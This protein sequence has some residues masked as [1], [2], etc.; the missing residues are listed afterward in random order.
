MIRL[1][2]TVAGRDVVA[3]VADDHVA[4]CEIVD[5]VRNTAATERSASAE[6]VAFTDAR[7]R[8]GDTIDE[9]GRVGHELPSLPAL[10]LAVHVIAGVDAGRVVMLRPQGDGSMCATIGRGDG[11]DVRLASNAVSKRHCTITVNDATLRV[12]DHGSRNGTVVRGH[13][14][15]DG[16]ADVDFGEPIGC[17]PAVVVVRAIPSPD[18]PA[19]VRAL[20]ADAPTGPVPY[21]RSP[22]DLPMAPASDIELPAPPRK[23]RTG[24]P[25]LIGLLLPMAMAAGLVWFTGQLL[26]ALFALMGPVMMMVTTA[27]RAGQNR[28]VRKKSRRRY[29]QELADFAEEL[30]DACNHEV[31]RRRE[32]CPDLA[33]LV[34]RGQCASAALWSRRRN[35]PNFMTLSVGLAE[36][37]WEPPIA[38]PPDDLGDLTDIVEAGR[39]LHAA[40]VLVEASAGTTIGLAGERE[41]A[42]ASARG[43]L[44]QIAILHGPAEVRALIVTSRR[45]ADDWDWAKWLP[46]VRPS[47][48]GGRLLVVVADDH[49]LVDSASIDDVLADTGAGSDIVAVIDTEGLADS[50]DVAIRRLLRTP[51][52]PVTGIV[53]APTADGLP[54]VCEL[55]IAH[56]DADGEATC[57]WPREAGRTLDVVIGGLS[58]PTA[59][60]VAR[61]LARLVDPDAG[62]GSATLPTRVGQAELLGLDAAAAATVT[63]RWMA[64]TR[65]ELVVGLGETGPVSIDL[66]VHGPHVLVVG[67]RGTGKT[68]QLAA[69]VLALAG[70]HPP[71]H[72]HLV[73]WG[74]SF[75]HLHRLPHVASAVSRIDETTLFQFTDGLDRE[76][77][78]RERLRSQRGDAHSVTDSGGDSGGNTA[79][80][81]PSDATA[82]SS[83]P[84]LVVVIDDIDTITRI[85]PAAADGF[86]RLLR[87]ARGLGVHVLWSTSRHNGGSMNELVDLSATRM[88]LRVGSVP[89]SNDLLGTDAA[90]LLERSLPGRGYLVAGRG[91][92]REI[93]GGAVSVG[94]ARPGDRIDLVAFDLRTGRSGFANAAAGPPDERA[95]LA[96][97]TAAGATSVRPPDLLSTAVGA[98]P[99]TA[100][101]GLLELLGIDSSEALATI[102]E[103]WNII[104]DE[105]FLRVPIGVDPEMRPVALDLKESALAGMGPHG[106]LVGATGS[107]KSELLRTLVSGLAVTH[108]PDLLA[109]VLIDFKGGAS[110][111]NLG[112]LPHVAGVVTNL[113]DDLA[114]V[115][116]ILAALG[117]EQRRRQELL[118]AAGNLGNVREYREA[119]HAGTLP[120][121][122]AD[123]PLPTLLVVVDE[124]AELLDQEPEFIDFF[125]TI[126]RVGRSL[127]IHLLLASQ[128]LEEGKLRGLDTY[129][130]Y[131]LGLRTFSAAESRIVLGVP[132]AFSLPTAPGGGYLKVGATAFDRFQASY[133]SGP[134]SFID[135]ASNT[136]SDNTPLSPTTTGPGST[137]PGPTTIN[138]IL[139]H[140]AAAA[141]PVHQI[142]LAPMNGELALDPVFG[143]AGF[144]HDTQRGFAAADWP[145]TARLAVP[146]GIVDE[147]ARQ[148][149]LPLIVDFVGAHGSLAIAGAPQ[150]GK[151][152]MLRTIVLSLAVTHTP[153]E[154]QIY[155]LDFG[156]GTLDALDAL[157]HVGTV[158]SRLQ[159]E[160]VSRSI[161]HVSDLLDRREALFAEHGI[162]SIATFR[163]RRANGEFD[164]PIGGDVFLVIDGWA[165]F[166][167]KFEQ[168]EPVIADLAARGLGYGVHVVVTMNRWTEMRPVV[169]D[170]IGGRLELRLNSPLD[171]A[172]DRRRAAVI[173]ADQP[174]R[175]LHPSTLMYQIALPRLDGV[176]SLDHLQEATAA[177]V[178][179]IA[180]RWSGASAPPVV[181]L[182]TSIRVDELPVD[183]DRVDPDAGAPAG[184]AVGLME[185]GMSTWRFDLD[186]SEPHFFVYGDGESGKTTFLQ[187]WLTGLVAQRSP[188]QAQVLLVDYRRTL[189]DVV[190]EDHLFAY[191]ASEPALRDVVDQLVAT[192]TARLP[193]ADVTA[194]QLRAR[195]WWSG[196]ELFVV[197]DDYDLVV[198]PS[199]N[200]LSGLLPLIAQGRDVGLHIVVARR[201][202]G[203]AKMMFEPVTGRL[204]EISPA[205]LILSGDRDEGPVI[206]SVRASFQPPGRGIVVTR[207]HP[208]SLVQVAVTDLP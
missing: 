169:L 64:A 143:G 10:E 142:W 171:S 125:L 199:G 136:T 156:G 168:W 43:L 2:L 24:R 161:S 35:H 152:L 114:L 37:P 55:V 165:A 126:G 45:H 206:G 11:V 31:R 155:G 196:P 166:R 80:A 15:G 109:F 23:P 208:P 79:D 1:P 3:S 153:D 66:D 19:K 183:N 149:Q 59:T 53:I 110:F 122:L 78:R 186:G 128:R 105:S 167:E 160:L 187:T 192:A 197:V 137:S 6:M 50:G 120:P 54:D 13:R 20:F 104:D 21:Y 83:E 162:D 70:T 99:A 68:E 62:G 106:L 202:A 116:R 18:T 82:A 103:R 67:G 29:R 65:P 179:H 93:Q 139:D 181:L 16:G 170:A 77:T 203:A 63:A 201:V 92:P 148:R 173:R 46:H 205:G 194:A 150:S 145:G 69:M 27:D 207:R 190:P 141:D 40:P 41:A 30:D 164:D 51:G 158:A 184:V 49:G 151:S 119:R 88:V 121:E 154:I 26:Y 135:P 60:A 72:L 113:A 191:A 36:T 200:P 97:I 159:P 133:V 61:S 74:E 112:R 172:I 14:V 107:G 140:L 130:S 57:R 47:F 195:S 42:L 178:A 117:G 94:A 12:V 177:A 144:V 85:L 198:T 163:R 9:S 5:L 8:P 146:I 124:F 102:P 175:G 108:S 89:D 176:D 17:G 180:D 111:A 39:T 131:R 33:E 75:G 38:E 56:H 147:P 189:L 44:T 123:E 4:V 90:A 96:L 28:R 134:V 185:H 100:S 84:S 138:A 34:R 118:A 48:A 7:I 101:P 157:P 115:D 52:A 98:T 71:E 127:G 132:D 129:L 86:I 32:I 76:L 95:L 174:G 204:R 188:D 81:R 22:V 87:R 58:A 73:L 25:G 193:G 91:E 182:P